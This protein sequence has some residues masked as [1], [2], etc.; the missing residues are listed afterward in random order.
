M[1]RKQNEQLATMAA[2]A[3]ET[4]AQASVDEMRIAAE[5]KYNALKQQAKESLAQA[6]D[7]VAMAAEIA[8]LA[9]KDAKAAAKARINNVQATAKEK[10][11]VAAD[12]LN[13][14]T[15][16]I[17]DTIKGFTAETLNNISDKTAD[18]SRKL[19]NQ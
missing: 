19:S 8:R 7:N 17:K 11:A 5:A 18:L 9:A 16:Q 6:K 15:S 4:S 13:D 10:R 14:K 12:Y 3:A 2:K 1:T